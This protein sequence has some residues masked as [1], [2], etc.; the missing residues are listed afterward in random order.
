[1]IHHV[2]ANQSN[3][4]D[5]LSARGIQ[6][7]LGSRTVANHFCD[8][9]FVPATLAALSKA[10]PEDF[11][12]IGGGGLFMDYFVPFW[13][14][15]RSIAPRVP[16]AI[17]GVGACDMKRVPSRAPITLVSDIVKQ[18]KLCVVRDELTRNWLSNCEL[19]QAVICPT[20]NA[21]HEA[22][23]EK[24][25]LLHLDHYDNVGA[26]IF[27]RMVVIAEEFAART[28]R[29][30]LKANNLISAGKEDALLRTLALYSSSDLVVTSRLHGAIIAL[31]MGRRVLAVSGDN[32]MESFMCAAGLSDWVCGLDE[33]D[34]L[35]ERLEKLSEQKLPA[36][37]IEEGRRQ[38]L[39]V[40]QKV[41]A[42][43]PDS[44]RTQAAP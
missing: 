17:W 7:L 37:F 15:F 35:P 36:G 26:E 5:W 43:L 29:P 18:S 42:M 12:I 9:P 11:V 1:M 34:L 19:P 23:V 8:E 16:F 24:A 20:V 38:N 25:G 28:G 2:Y 21:V 41:I 6:S 31:A 4:G 39:S 40:A 3:I 10:G 13:D 44:Q 30:Y 27:E 22:A 33:I 32:K 14:G